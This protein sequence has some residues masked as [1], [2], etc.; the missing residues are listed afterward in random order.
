VAAGEKDWQQER[1]HRGPPPES[2]RPR[3]AGT[4][5]VPMFR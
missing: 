3:Q 1:E 4:T 2:R 5:R